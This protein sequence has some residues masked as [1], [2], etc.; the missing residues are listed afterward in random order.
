[1]E[2]RFHAQLIASHAVQDNVRRAR[3]HQPTDRPITFK[4]RG[5]G[6]LGLSRHT[7]H[8]PNPDTLGATRALLLQK[9]LDVL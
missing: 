7:L 5:Q 8:N 3:D 6:H 2:D 9:F 4:R 1:M